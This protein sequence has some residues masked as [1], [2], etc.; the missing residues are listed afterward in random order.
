MIHLLRKEERSWLR[1]EAKQWSR[2]KMRLN[3]PSKSVFRPKRM[4]NEEA[5][6]RLVDRK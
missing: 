1:R 6:I 2:I 4:S 3:R 5:I